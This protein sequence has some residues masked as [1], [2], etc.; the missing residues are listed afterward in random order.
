MDT[1]IYTA[2]LRRRSVR[3]YQD[4][5]V[6][7]ET[8]TALV[9]AATAAPSATNRRPWA[10]VAVTDP[11]VL[12][13]LRKTHMFSNMNAPAAI[14][15]CGDMKKA[16]K[17]PGRDFWIQDCSAAVENILMTAL[18]FGLGTVW[19]GVHPI[20]QNVKRV[21]AAIELPEHIIPLG[22]LF[23][24]VPDKEPEPRTQFEPSDLHWDRY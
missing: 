21:S 4:T 23:I 1:P 17:G 10:F 6:S 3:K 24:G 7:R 12:K 18:D 19:V 5:P 8:L 2:A 11:E 14:E 20:A 9:E 13:K 16:A 22:L 15:V